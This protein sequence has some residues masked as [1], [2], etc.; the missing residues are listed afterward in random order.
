MKV[1]P[2]KAME[3]LKDQPEGIISAI[4][5]QNPPE[6][7]IGE[8]Q[9]QAV[10]EGALLSAGVGEMLQK[11]RAESRLTLRQAAN[12]VGMQHSQWLQVQNNPSGTVELRTLARIAQ[13]MGYDLHL[14]LMPKK[15]TGKQ[16]AIETRVR[17]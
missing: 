15:R 13:G 6:A 7:E 2:K 5:V 14:A 16:K 11:A 4:S 8:Q 3:W 1:D 17:L 10:F 9:F 12:N